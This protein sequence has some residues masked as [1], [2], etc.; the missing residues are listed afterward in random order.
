MICFCA[1]NTY[2]LHPKNPTT[3]NKFIKTKSCINAAEIDRTYI[4]LDKEKALNRDATLY[5]K[6]NIQ[7]SVYQKIKM[8]LYYCIV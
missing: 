2:L 3:R 7:K 1:M 6:K 5:V 4:I 8:T